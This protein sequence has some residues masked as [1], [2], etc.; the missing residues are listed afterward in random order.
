METEHKTWLP[1]IAIGLIVGFMLGYVAEQAVPP[2]SVDA[3]SEVQEELVRVDDLVYKEEVQRIL[4]RFSA[5]QD[6]V[7]AYQQLL[8]LRVPAAYT[9]DHL[10]LV[11]ALGAAKDGESGATVKLDVLISSINWLS[12]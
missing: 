11:L 5:D 1:M 10:A 9:A 6:V 7:Y 3:A 4:V 8:D 12:L 2:S